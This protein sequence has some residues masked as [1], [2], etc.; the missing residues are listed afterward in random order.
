LY[1]RAVLISI[2]GK[3]ELDAEFGAEVEEP[4]GAELVTEFEVELGVEL[5]D[6]LGA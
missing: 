1:D 2:V 4:L 5:D 6:P 3:A